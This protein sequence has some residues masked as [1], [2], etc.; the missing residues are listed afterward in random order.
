MKRIGRIALGNCFCRGWWRCG[1]C[2]GRTAR[3][4]ASFRRGL[5]GCGWLGFVLGWR[6]GPG[7]S[8]LLT[9]SVGDRFV[10]DETD[11]GR[12]VWASGPA[13]SMMTRW[14]TKSVD[15]VTYR[16]S[17]NNHPRSC[18]PSGPPEP[19]PR[20]ALWHHQVPCHV[21]QW[22]LSPPD[23]ANRMI[24]RKQR[25]TRLCYTAWE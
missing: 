1:I 15:S 24:W 21:A 12:R 11:R 10:D 7:C 3:Y 13:G 25:L 8:T 5:F 18:A 14:T 22:T 6:S 4:S 9:L 20:H 23:A 17:R 16:V 19:E 2:G